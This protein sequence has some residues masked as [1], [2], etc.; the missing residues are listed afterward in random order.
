MDWNHGEEQ[1]HL[2]FREYIH[3]KSRSPLNKTVYN[4]LLHNGTRKSQSLFFHFNEHSANTCEVNPIPRELID[5]T[6]LG[7]NNELSI[8]S[9][10]PYQAV[11]LGVSYRI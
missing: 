7:H 4:D 9:L 10:E 2:T 1:K 11:V 3:S 6:S 8:F 5:K